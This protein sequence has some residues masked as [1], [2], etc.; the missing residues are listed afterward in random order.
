MLLVLSENSIDS[1]WVEKE[2]ETAFEKERRTKQTVLFPIRLDETIME[3]DQSWA[4]DIRRTINIGNFS[5]W[6]IS[7]EYQ[8]SF[9]KLLNNLKI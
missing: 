9:E 5:K 8:K 6:N 3:T 2:V 1:E 7:D 4:A